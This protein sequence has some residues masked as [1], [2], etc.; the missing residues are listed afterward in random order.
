MTLQAL[1]VI[2]L[3]PMCSGYA[4]WTLMPSSG[5]RAVAGWLLRFK[6]PRRL[7]APL[8]KAAAAPAASCGCSGCDRAAPAAPAGSAQALRFHPRSK[9]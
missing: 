5:R 8:A 7:A 9:P 2:M 6:L 4:V 3:V 1:I